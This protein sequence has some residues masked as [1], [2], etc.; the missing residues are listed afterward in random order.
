MKKLN[1]FLKSIIDICISIISII[2]LSPLLLIILILIKLSS[3]G[4]IFF[5]QQRLGKNGKIFEILKFRTMIVGADKIGD[6]IFVKSEEDTRI[7]KIGKFLR[8]TSLDELPQII[9]VIKGD[10]SIVGP[11]PPLTYH[12]Y[13]YAEYPYKQKRRFQMKPGITGLAQITVRNSVSWDE[14]IEYD[15]QYISDF[16]I[17]LDI[18]II[19][20]TI[21]KVFIR[22]SIYRNS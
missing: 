11:R 9:N 14:R 2:V 6:G 8:A 20:G 4:P 12:P 7:T 22:E 19:L 16:N 5:R 13:I 21:K 15:N 1:L 10:M 17:W 3:P 18:K